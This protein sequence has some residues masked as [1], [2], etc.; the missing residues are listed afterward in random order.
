MSAPDEQRLPGLRF[1]VHGRQRRSELV[2]VHACRTTTVVAK[3]DWKWDAV[4]GSARI[5]GLDDLA[6]GFEPVGLGEIFIRAGG[7]TWTWPAASTPRWPLSDE[8]R[9]QSVRIGGIPTSE[10]HGAS[11]PGRTEPTGSRVPTR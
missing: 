1:G 4:E 5:V 9:Y 10:R 7:T 3:L 11:R 2:N 6:D 8:P